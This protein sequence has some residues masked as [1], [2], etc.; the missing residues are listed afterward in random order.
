MKGPCEPPL[1]ALLARE[2]GYTDNPADRGGPTNFGITEHQ[3]RAYGF[4]GDMRAFPLEAARAIYRA[5][6]WQRPGF[7][8]VA[9]HAP[10]LALE[11]FDTGVNM[12]PQVAAT[13][14]Q[15]ALNVLN[16]GGT[17]YPDILADGDIGPMT[18]HAL[19]GLLSRRAN[20]ETL[21][22]RA[23]DCLQGARYI[24]IA[25]KNPSQEV[26]EAGWLGNRVGAA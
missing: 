13:F 15:R 17:D 8:Q 22:I 14:L 10:L 26:F 23:C 5:V 3:A 12:G 9:L 7:E 4:T 21:L 16:R 18:L 24:E 1:E 6:Y 20:G 11:L 25:E 19:D 2:G